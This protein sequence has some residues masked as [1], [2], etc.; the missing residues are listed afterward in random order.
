V[1]LPGA[2]SW[3]VLGSVLTDAPLVSRGSAT[4]TV[5]DQCGPCRRCLDACPTGALVGAGELDA[6]RCLAWLVQAPGVFPFQYREALGDRL[7]GCDDC[8]EVCPVN[9][10]GARLDPPGPPEPGA[11]PVADVLDLLDADDAA[12]LAH[13]GRWYIPRREPRYLRRNALL[14]L[15]N[16]A[17]PRDP[18]TVRALRRTLASDDPIIQA[19]AVWAAARLGRPDLLGPLRDR[20]AAGATDARASLDPL[21]AAELAAAP[22][23]TPRH[24]AAPHVT[25]RHPAGAAASPPGAAGA[26]R[27]ARPARRR[28]DPPPVT[29]SGATSPGVPPS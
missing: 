26:T 14:V 9:K 21:V 17:D 16:T 1:L 19:H 22:H 5:D 18:H 13:F 28:V 10:L 6:R 7:Y 29:P 2:G 24:P 20:E 11:E 27:P 23:V 25:P 8:Q 3:F 12:L 4:P 15:G